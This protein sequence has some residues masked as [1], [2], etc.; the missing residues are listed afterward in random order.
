M[1]HRGLLIPGHCG[2]WF[3]GRRPQPRRATK[4]HGTGARLA[5]VCR[6]GWLR[7]S[8]SWLRGSSPI[9]AAAVGFSGRARSGCSVASTNRTSACSCAGS[10]RA[11]GTGTTT[12]WTTRPSGQA[13]R[14]SSPVSSRPSRSA[15][16]SGSSSPGSPCP[17]TW[18]QACWRACQRRSTCSVGRMHDQRRRGDVQGSRPIPRFARRHPIADTAEVLR[19]RLTCAAGIRRGPRREDLA[20]HSRITSSP[21][22]RL[23]RMS[24]GCRARRPHPRGSRGSDVLRRDRGLRS[25]VEPGVHD[26]ECRRAGRAIVF[27]VPRPGDGSVMEHGALDDG[28]G[29]RLAPTFVA[30]EAG[31]VGVR[32]QHVVVLGEEPRR[33]RRVGIGPRCVGQIEQLAASLVA[34]RP[35]VAAAAVRPPR[36]SRSGATTT[37]RRRPSPARTRRGSGGPPRRSRDEGPVRR[38][39]QASAVVDATCASSAPHAARRHLDERQ[40]VPACVGERQARRDRGSGP[41]TRRGARRPSAGARR[42]MSCAWAR[43]GPRSTPSSAG[44][45]SRW[46]A[47][48]ASSTGCISGRRS[49][50]SS[51]VTRCRVPRIATMRTTARSTR[52]RP[53]SSGS[54]RSSRDHSPM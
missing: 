21:S 14:S 25:S 49:R 26:H 18:S 31:T 22:H 8:S 6:G 41:R 45:W 34:E 20:D 13:T 35:G 19:L 54:N 7:P 30:H 16:A 44:P 42:E 51:A 33:R 27:D 28:C 52:S 10:C 39:S 1:W 9:A 38:P 17:P 11:A 53:S 5:R 24:G 3:D 36:A 48:S 15:I 46:R 37:T 23:H 43:T 40:Q 32:Q 50:Q 2:T 47:S 12:T 29:P 4:C